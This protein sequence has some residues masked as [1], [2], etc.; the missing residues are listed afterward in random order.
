MRFIPQNAPT[1]V[2]LLVQTQRLLPAHKSSLE[3]CALALLMASSAT[4]DRLQTPL[5]C[6]CVVLMVLTAL[7]AVK[8]CVCVQLVELEERGVLVSKL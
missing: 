5:Q 6:S 4:L 3:E 1:L 7:A 8:Q 2:Y